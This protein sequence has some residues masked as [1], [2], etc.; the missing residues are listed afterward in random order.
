[1]AEV[2]AR[3]IVKPMN[4]VRAMD[5]VK[6]KTEVRNP[7]LEIRKGASNEYNRRQETR[8]KT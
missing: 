2:R 3:D 7:K 8:R 6:P 1:M 4:R 5:I